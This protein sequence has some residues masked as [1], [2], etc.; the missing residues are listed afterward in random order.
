[1][2]RRKD[3]A[4]AKRTRPELKSALHPSDDA[5]GRQVVG[6][7]LDERATL[8]FLGQVTVFSCEP[9]QLRSVHRR[10]QKGMVGQIAVRISKVNAITIKSRANC[11]SGISGRGRNEHALKA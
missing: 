5:I 11:A 4:M 2:R 3:A 9:C 1:M 7:L 6:N 8:A 10:S